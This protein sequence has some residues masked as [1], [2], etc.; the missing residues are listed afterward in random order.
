MKL[1]DGASESPDSDEDHGSPKVLL[2]DVDWV[3]KAAEQGNGGL[4][5]AINAAAE[6]GILPSKMWVGTLGMPTDSLKEHTRSDIERILREDHESLPVFVSDSEFDG[7]YSHFCRTV[8]WPAFHYQVQESPRHKEYD[9]HTWRQ[10]VKV[11][12]IFADRIASN[13]KPG[14]SIWIN[15]Y[16]LLLLPAILR[17]KLPEAEIAFFMHAAFPSSEV[18]RCLAARDAL[19]EGLLG[20]DLVGFQTDEYCHHFL[21]TCSRLLSLE[22]TVNG[23]QLR[24]RHIHVKK[25]PIGI[26]PNSL[27]EIRQTAEV[28][29]WVSKIRDRYEGKHLIVGRDRL[30]AP[31]GIKQKLLSYELFLKKY[32]KWRENVRLDEIDP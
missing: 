23:V 12:E 2:S 8:L 17:R 11:N 10:Y 20:A 22:V 32:P 28:Q 15:D 6:A 18:F 4:R 3:V 1:V 31:G 16:H 24:G 9:D 25:I 27:D 5:N 21:Q 29:D 13:W 30:D 19:L 7:H 14:D 26:D